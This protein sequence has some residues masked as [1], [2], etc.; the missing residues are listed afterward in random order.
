MKMNKFDKV[1]LITIDFK[2]SKNV[3]VYENDEV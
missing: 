1:M 2:V 3:Y